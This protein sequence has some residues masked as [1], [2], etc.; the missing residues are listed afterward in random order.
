[1][2]NDSRT[3]GRSR[4]ARQGFD[5]ANGGLCDSGRPAYGFAWRTTG[6][7][8]TAAELLEGIAQDW[9][10]VAAAAPSG[11]EMV[12]LLVLSEPRADV[13]LLRALAQALADT[14]GLHL[15]QRPWTEADQ[16]NED[17]QELARVQAQLDQADQAERA[18]FGAALKGW[19]KDA[20]AGY[21]ST[22]GAGELLA[23][24]RTA[25]TSETP[26][27]LAE[28]TEAKRAARLADIAHNPD[29]RD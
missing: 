8:V 21:R 2:A 12:R 17:V 15:E 20:I 4:T 28:L 13:E 18:T 23:D 22:R 6:A 27:L 26:R 10:D 14:A 16:V 19:A 3:G 24:I 29:G 11:A 9:R 7:L 1:M 5:E 25:D